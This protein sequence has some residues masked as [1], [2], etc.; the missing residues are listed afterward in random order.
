M[1]EARGLQDK[2]NSL[3][4]DG[5]YADAIAVF[6]EA[7]RVSASAPLYESVAQCQMML[8]TNQSVQDAVD[9]GTMATQLAPTWAEGHLTLGR[10]LRNAGNMHRAAAALVRVLEIDPNHAEA[11]EELQ[12]VQ[13]ALENQR[14][15]S[16]RAAA[17]SEDPVM[18][19]RR[20]LLHAR[21]RRRPLWT[22]ADWRVHR[23]ATFPLAEL[24]KDCRGNIKRVEA[25]AMSVE[26]FGEMFQRPRLPA[27]LCGIMDSWRAM[28]EWT[29]SF[30]SAAF[31]FQ[32][33]VLDHRF[34]LRMR[35]KDFQHYMEKQEDDTPLYIF[36]HLFFEHPIS[37]HLAEDY[38]IPGVFSAD[39]FQALSRPLCPPCRWLLVG[40]RRSGSFLHK[41]PL[42]TSA[43][44]ALVRGT[45]LWVLFPPSTPSKWLCP[46]QWPPCSAESAS[47]WFLLWWHELRARTRQWP[48]EYQPIEF[49]QHAGEVVFVPARWWHTVLNLDDT[50]AVTQNFCSSW[51]CQ[52]V[53][54]CSEA[55]HPIFS[56]YFRACLQR[57]FPELYCKMAECSL[58][59]IPGDDPTTSYIVWGTDASEAGPLCN[60]RVHRANMHGSASSSSDDGFTVP[61]LSRGCTG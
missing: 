47:C 50:V 14:H 33:M 19:W 60:D 9:A 3:A 43:W 48:A 53:W 26:E 38:T 20:K 22:E 12:L 15:R 13:Q 42:G 46:E 7:I 24:L 40:P 16:M 37:H 51:N 10:A 32:K 55:T 6:E 45:K 30:F 36:D 56:K 4:Q 23:F 17:S 29:A 28:R 52:D 25:A 44:N 5:R 41:D 54:C 21:S 27:L 39:I 58:K 57:E 2:G 8:E 61:P 1:A 34:G 18:R 31:G 35:M 49:V 11:S 59:R